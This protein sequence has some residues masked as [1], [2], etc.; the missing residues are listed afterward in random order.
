MPTFDFQCQKCQ[1]VFEFN[2]PF[3]STE[4]PACPKCNSKRTEKQFSAPAVV[5]K[6]SGWYKTDSRPVAKAPKAEAVT[7]EPAKASDKTE[8]KPADSAPEKPTEKKSDAKPAAEKKS[9]QKKK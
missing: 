3:G 4:K 1:H 6:G 2:R 8:A 5:F 7:T 9:E